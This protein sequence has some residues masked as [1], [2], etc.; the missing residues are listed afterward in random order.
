MDED[1]SVEGLLTGVLVLASVLQ[2]VKGPGCDVLGFGLRVQ[3]LGFRASGL[4]F[5]SLEV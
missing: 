3:D 4:G 5:N 1:D 2:R